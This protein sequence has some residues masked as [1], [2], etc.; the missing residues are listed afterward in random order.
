M[1][2][3][4]QLL[5]DEITDKIN[6]STG[7]IVANYQEF[8]SA[9]AREFRNTLSDVG[10]DFEVVRKRVFLKAAET[11]GLKFELAQLKGHIGLIF[12]NEDSTTLAKSAVKYSE[13]NSDCISMLG[14]NIDGEQ[15]SGEEIIALAKLPGIKELRS[16]IVGLLAAPMTQTVAVMQAALTSVL[17]CMEEKSKQG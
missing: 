10:G 12:A 13:E 17:Y 14:G 15:C 2:E 16:Q 8:T 11:L 7:F 3:E 6:A 4:K 5:L 9:R 1:R